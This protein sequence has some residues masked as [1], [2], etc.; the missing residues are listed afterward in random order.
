MRR[1]ILLLALRPGRVLL[2][3]TCHDAVR[4]PSRT[5]DETGESETSPLPDQFVAPRRKFGEPPECRARLRTGVPR[6]CPPRFIADSSRRALMA[7]V[8]QA[9]DP[10]GG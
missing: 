5:R 10:R 8:N 1:A 3:F 2:G 6:A 9:T 4:H 7:A